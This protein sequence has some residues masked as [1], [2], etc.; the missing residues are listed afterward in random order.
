MKTLFFGIKN[1]LNGLIN[2]YDENGKFVII[3]NVLVTTDC[4]H[5]G[6]LNTYTRVMDFQSNGHHLQIFLK[7]CN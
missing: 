7:M 6:S 5:F 1:T 3:K 4:V 2:I